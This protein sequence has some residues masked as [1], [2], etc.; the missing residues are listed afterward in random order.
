[1]NEKWGDGT[2]LET[3]EYYKGIADEYT[4]WW[5]PFGDDILEDLCKILN[6]RFRQNTIDVHVAPW[7]YAFSVPMV[8]GVIFKTKDKLI[9][10]LTH[11]IIHRLLTDNTTYEYSHDFVALWRGMFGDELSQNALIHVPVH[12]VMKKLYVDIMDRPDLVK[13][14]QKSVSKNPSYVEAWEYVDRHGYDEIVKKLRQDID[15][16]GE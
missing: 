5:E 2:P 8:I 16:R 4:R 14:D 9:N 6:L 7:F 1:M 11:E 13:L 3:F 15:E 10:V 12:A